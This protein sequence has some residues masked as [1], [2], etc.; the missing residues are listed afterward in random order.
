M[1]HPGLTAL[2]TW[3]ARGWRERE[4][5]WRQEQRLWRSEDMAFRVK[6]RLA[7][8]EE[9]QL[10][11]LKY[12]WR[13]EDV[14]QRMVN[15]SHYLWS[16]FSELNRRDVEEKSEHLRSLSWLTGLITSFTMTSPVEFNAPQGISTARLTSY[17]ICTAVVPMLM[18]TSTIISIY[19]LKSIL[20]MGKW[21]VAEDAEEEFMA[22][23]RL[24]G[25]NSDPFEAPPAPR[26][27][28][29][30]FWDIRCKDDWMISFRLFIWGVS[31]FLG[32][33]C[34]MGFIKFVF[35]DHLAISFSIIIGVSF[36][37]W[38]WIQ[39]KWGGYLQK[40]QSMANS[41]VALAHISPEV[42]PPRDPFKWHIKPLSSN[43]MNIL[44]RQGRENQMWL[45]EGTN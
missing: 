17:A 26:R 21:F 32:L 40:A 14:Q 29:E 39:V 24:Y 43:R 1:A 25:E 45:E 36:A 3:V 10:H 16:R 37:A 27:T 20:K 13:E 30:Q 42:C 35:N 31:F 34:T 44:N 18:T 15:N 12:R 38:L 33:L 28:F 23:C 9:Y 19:L 4:R 41:S 2:D 11:E 7:R 5:L 22:R 6:E 8:N